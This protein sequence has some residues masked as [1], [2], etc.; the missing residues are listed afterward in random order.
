[1]SPDPNIV[2][3][4]VFL[5]EMRRTKNKKLA[6]QNF[7]VAVLLFLTSTGGLN[8][9]VENTNPGRRSAELNNIWARMRQATNN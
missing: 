8:F 7:K 1:M 9:R 5:C 4:N 2:A 3:P 6:G